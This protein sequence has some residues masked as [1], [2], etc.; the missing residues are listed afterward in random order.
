M[1]GGHVTTLPILHIFLYERFVSRSTLTAWVS[2]VFQF[3]IIWENATGAGKML[4]KIIRPPQGKSFVSLGVIL[5]AIFG[6]TVPAHAQFAEQV[7]QDG[8]F[9]YWTMNE[10]GP[11]AADNSFSASNEAASFTDNLEFGIPGLADSNQTAVRFNGGGALNINNS[12]ASN[13]GGP[14]TQKTIEL[15]FSADDA[16]TETEQMLYEQGGSTRGITVFVRDG[17]VFAGV[18]NSAADGGTAAPWPFGEVGAGESELAFVSTDIDSDT[19][20]HLAFVFDG[21]SAFNEDLEL[22]GSITGYLNGEEFETVGGI[23]TLYAHTDP[24]NVGN[25]GQTHFDP[26]FSGDTP[27]GTDGGDYSFSGII[28]DVAMYNVALSAEQVSAHY[29][30]REYVIGDFDGDGT[31]AFADFLRLAENFN[32]PGGYGQ[33]DINFSGQVDLEDFSIF[34][35]T[36]AAA[37]GEPQAASVPEPSSAWL[38]LASAMA[39]PLLRRRRR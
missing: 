20:Y 6:Y 10:S 34:R 39:L 32:K 22:D 8:A 3:L 9:A 33:G 2:I 37:A 13:T 23:G 27:F 14:W 1:R 24:I 21:A 26:D 31:V 19:P 25:S 18:H 30:S 5:L 29:D 28:D 15:W 17:K 16:D 11:G 7:V 12:A 4:M 38:I 35:R 36:L